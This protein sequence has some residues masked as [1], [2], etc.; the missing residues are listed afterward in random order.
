MQAWELLQGVVAVLERRAAAGTTVRSKRREWRRNSGSCRLRRLDSL[1]SCFTPSQKLGTC[2]AEEEAFY[3]R[4]LEATTRVNKRPP[5]SI[6]D[7]DVLSPAVG[8]ALQVSVATLFFDTFLGLSVLEPVAAYAPR[9]VEE[10]V[11]STVDAMLDIVKAAPRYKFVEE[12][13][14]VWVIEEELA[15]PLRSAFNTTLRARWPATPSQV[16]LRSRGLFNAAAVA[17]A[18]L[19]KKKVLRTA[20]IAAHGLH[21]CGLLSCDQREVSVKQFKYCGDCEEEWYCCAEQQVLHWKD[22]KPI[23]RARTAAAAMAAVT[24]D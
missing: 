5:P 9:R 21:P 3:R 17:T 6:Q 4:W 24:L 13:R 14:F 2:R 7:L 10:F 18:E 11:L 15:D 12:S 20:D 22:H 16:M 1:I 19:E 23:C 8:Y